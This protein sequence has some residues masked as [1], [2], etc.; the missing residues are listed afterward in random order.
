LR[1]T[2]GLT[3]ALVGAALTTAV[4]GVSVVMVGLGA[5]AFAVD[6]MCFG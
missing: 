6:V 4:D 3:A 2:G 1:L 5:A